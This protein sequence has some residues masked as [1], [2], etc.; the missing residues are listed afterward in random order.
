P[1]SPVPRQTC[2]ERPTGIGAGYPG[3]N[4]ACS[5][6]PVRSDDDVKNTIYKPSKQASDTKLKKPAKRGAFPFYEKLLKLPFEFLENY[7]CVMATKT[8]CITHGRVHG[9]PLRF[10]EC[11][12]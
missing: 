12:V 6:A 11:K 5:S 3:R 9:L 8:K 4:P 10:I 1:P 7:R 2:A